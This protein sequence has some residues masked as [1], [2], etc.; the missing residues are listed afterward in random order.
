MAS[1][2]I[3][4]VGKMNGGSVDLRVALLP[5]T[6]D[7]V[8]AAMAFGARLYEAGAARSACIN[9]DELAGYDE[10]DTFASPFDSAQGSLSASEAAF[11]TFASLSTGAM[12]RADSLYAQDIAQDGMLQAM[13]V[14]LRS[15]Q[16]D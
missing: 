6:D 5:K 12:L 7:T 8:L 1:Q 9:Q 3:L 15:P 16:V 10:A 14:R 13:M 11:D 4:A 2:H